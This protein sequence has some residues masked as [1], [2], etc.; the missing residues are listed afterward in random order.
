MSHRFLTVL[1]IALVAGLLI[2]LGASA[3][4]AASEAPP[5]TP[6]GAPDLQG[7][8]DF[9]SLTPMQRPTD[10]AENDVFSAE[11]AATFSEETIRRRSRDSGHVRPS[12]SLQ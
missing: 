8:W 5:R 4:S 10:I 7:V 9:R 1:L 12:R 3:Q 11:E 2:P 6:W